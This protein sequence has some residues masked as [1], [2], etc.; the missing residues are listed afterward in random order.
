MG[1]GVRWVGLYDADFTEGYIG[2]Q[3]LT[4]P[5]PGKQALTY[6]A[7]GCSQIGLNPYTRVS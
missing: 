1:G 5:L 4:N 3:Y 2:V 6:W 7:L